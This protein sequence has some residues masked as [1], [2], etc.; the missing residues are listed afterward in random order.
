MWQ[1]LELASE[2]KSDL[3]NTVDLG[4]KWLVDFN[5]GKTQLVL[6]D[7]SNKTGAIDVKIGGSVLEGKSFFKMLWLTF[8]SKLHY[9]Y[10]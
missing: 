2:L 10:C 4:R 3:R 5:A 9:L 8:S 1:Q 7:P 6:F